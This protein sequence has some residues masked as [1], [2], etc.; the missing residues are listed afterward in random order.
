[1]LEEQ[2]KE[3]KEKAAQNIDQL[4]EEKIKPL[5]T[6]AT[7][8]FL[9]VTVKELT[10]DISAKL[11]KAPLLDF[12]ID[13][14]IKFKQA[15]KRFKKAYIEKMLELHLGN[16]SVVAREAGTDRRSIHRLIHQLH[17]PLD[18]IKKE[19]L[20]PYDMKLSL[21]SHAIEDVLDKYRAVLH[22]AKIERM[23][24][25]VSQLSEDLLRELPEKKLTIKE[26]EEDFE[27]QYIKKAL[28]GNNHNVTQT[29]KKIGLRYETLHR[30]M[31]VLGIA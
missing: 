3:E 1:M 4:L 15:K 8:K 24:K 2:Q 6:E 14:S 21:V 26:A 17:V 16:I 13:I 31:K 27:R 7:A 5:I 20:R 11:T 18:K 25:N 23:Y 19:L 29:A 12:P 9:G 30:K 10:E 22:P 28:L